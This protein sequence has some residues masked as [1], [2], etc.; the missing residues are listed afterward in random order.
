MSEIIIT[1]VTGN[2]DSI[3]LIFEK[4]GGLWVTK[5]PPNTADGKYAVQI[6][7]TL[8]NGF[9]E[10]W[11]GFLYML[12]GKAKMTLKSDKY[13]LKMKKSRF[14]ISMLSKKNKLKKRR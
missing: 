12:T 9:K 4:R 8:S 3:D 5:V 14:K 1:A 2:A 7:V 10:S 6:I 11:T 13:C